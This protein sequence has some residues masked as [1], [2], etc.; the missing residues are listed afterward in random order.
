MSTGD[1]TPTVNGKA[2]PE[3]LALTGA[4]L[5]VQIE[6]TAILAGQLQKTGKPI[7]N[8]ISGHALIDTGSPIT[9]VDIRTAVQK[10]GLEPTGVTEDEYGHGPERK[11]RAIYTVRV[12]FPGINLGP[13]DPCDAAGLEMEP[14]M[15]LGR[16]I[17]KNFV[18][19]YNGPQ[20]NFRLD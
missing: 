9:C 17:L 16:D 13:F 5:Q 3:I 8:P 7:P 1:I 18:F 20:G 2:G 19:T 6:V 15:I 10:L 11:I 4:R 14:I 12:V